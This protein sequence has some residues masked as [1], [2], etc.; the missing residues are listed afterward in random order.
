VTPVL[1]ASSK[2]P[3]EPDTDDLV[4]WLRERVV[5]MVRSGGRDLSLRQLGVLLT[6]E[7][8]GGPHTIKAVAEAMDVEAPGVARAADALEA[9]KLARR[10]TIKNRRAA[11]LEVTP[12][13]RALCRRLG[14][15]A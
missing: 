1:S 14:N 5:V 12:S 13:G 15:T 7:E 9:Y 10:L 4:S 6:I 11:R 2:G 8:A 3:V